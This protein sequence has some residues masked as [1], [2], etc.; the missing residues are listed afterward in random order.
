MAMKTHDILSY[1]LFTALMCLILGACSEEDDY[2]TVVEIESGN[3]KAITYDSAHF[4]GKVISGN[5]KEIGVCWGLNPNPTI[6]DSSV[7]MDNGNRTFDYTITGLSEGTQYYV[8][9]WARTSDGDIVYG[10]DKTCVTMAHGR[11]VVYVTDVVNIAEANATIVSKMLVD[12]GLEISEYGIVIGTEEGVHAQNGQKVALNIT[13]NAVK[14]LV[15]GLIDNQTYYVKA[16]AITNNET[17]Y[18]KEVSFTTSMYAGPTFQIETGNVTGESFDAKVTVTSGTP[19]A[20]LEYGLVYGTT[21]E[22]SVETDAKI[23]LGEGEDGKTLTIEDVKEGITYYVR[24]Y[25]TNKNGLYYGEEVTVLILSDRAMISTVETSFVTAHRAK[26]GGNITHLGLKNAPI[27]ETGICW[28]TSPS[29]TVDDQRVK[30]TATELGEFDA[31]QLFCLDPSTTYYA[32]AYVT[33]QYGTNYGEEVSFTTREAVGNYFTTNTEGDYFNAFNMTDTY[34]GPDDA[35]SAYQKEAYETV[36]KITELNNR[37]FTAYRYYLYADETGAPSFLVA[38]IVYKNS[39]GTSYR[40][41]WRTKMDVSDKFVYTCTHQEAYTNSKNY[42]NTAKNN[43]LEDKLAMATDFIINDSFVIDW[44]DESSTTISKTDK[45]AVFYMI[46][47][48]SPENFLRMGV[49]R[50]TGLTPYTPWW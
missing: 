36:K 7:S 10:E 15:E 48:H 30:S 49:F 27:T 38:N 32:R 45:T 43:G 13:C 40:A 1:W 42:I 20:V 18:S 34:P 33:N 8:R 23:V 2:S 31:L 21:S 41:I 9:A 11:P 35:Y 28:S 19:L 14:T 22:P 39:A 47:V 4:S 29:P 46:P 5:P 37:N 17:I 50:V 3:L 6:N 44:G 24:P 26:I 16:Y 12:G 25:A